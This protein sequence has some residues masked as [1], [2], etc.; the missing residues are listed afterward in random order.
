MSEH[1][2][3]DVKLKNQRWNAEM[4][5][6]AAEVS[7]AAAAHDSRKIS[8]LRWP[9]TRPKRLI[10]QNGIIIIHQLLRRSIAL[11][12]STSTAL[13][14]ENILTL[15]LTVRAHFETTGVMALMKKKLETFYAE[16]LSFESIDEFL[17]SAM[18]GSRYIEHDTEIVPKP[19]Q[20][21]N[22]IDSVDEFFKLLGITP[23]AQFRKQYD[24]LS[25]YC[26]PNF[27]GTSFTMEVTDTGVVF[28]DPRVRFQDHAEIVLHCLNMSLDLFFQFFDK[29]NEMLLGNEET[30]TAIK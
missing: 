13:D 5:K 8:E 24:L 25:E 28:F 16:K 20:A 15:A 29:C 23:V 1:K 21:M 9:S 22:G 10:G 19:V 6:L 7:K 27:H 11:C 3:L 14:D 18:L 17:K 12:D 30:P 4:Q 26:H 2:S